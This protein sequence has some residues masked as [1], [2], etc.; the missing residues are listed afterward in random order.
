MDLEVTPV[1]LN[2]LVASFQ[3]KPEALLLGGRGLATDMDRL[4]VAPLSAYL[5]DTYPKPRRL[6]ADWAQGKTI[7]R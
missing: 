7:F 3:S 2:A 5:F 1:L 4:L 6:C